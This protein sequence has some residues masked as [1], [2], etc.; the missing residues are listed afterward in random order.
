MSIKGNIVISFSSLLFFATLAILL[1]AL[2]GQ[3]CYTCGSTDN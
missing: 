1:V 2:V 3:F